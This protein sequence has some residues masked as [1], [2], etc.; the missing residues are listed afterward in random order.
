M[1]QRK[2]RCKIC[3]G[4]WGDN[5]LRRKGVFKKMI[6]CDTCNSNGNKMEKSK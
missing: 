1:I 5:I 3:N 6:V 2:D 4:L